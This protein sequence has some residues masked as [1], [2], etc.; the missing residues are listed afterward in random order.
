M[1]IQARNHS[2]F[3]YCVM[4]VVYQL[5]GDGALYINSMFRGKQ[6]QHMFLREWYN[7]MY[8]TWAWELYFANITAPLWA[9][10]ISPDGIWTMAFRADNIQVVDNIYKNITFYIEEWDTTIDLKTSPNAIVTT[11]DG[12]PGEEIRYGRKYNVYAFPNGDIVISYIDGYEIDVRAAFSD[13][14]A[15]V[16]TL[17]T[18]KSL[19]GL[20]PNIQYELLWERDCFTTTNLMVVPQNK[21]IRSYDDIE[22]RNKEGYD[23]S[24]YTWCVGR[25]INTSYFKVMGRYKSGKYNEYDDITS[26]AVFTPPSGTVFDTPNDYTIDVAAY[27]LEG[28]EYTTSFTMETWYEIDSANVVYDNTESG[29]EATTLEGAINECYARL[30]DMNTTLYG[31]RHK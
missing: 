2:P 23:I 24:Y 7:E 29:L 13:T 3:V 14:D 9:R 20:K 5:L 1:S 28:N 22:I 15:S 26:T 6:C 27:D 16:H 21:A 30:R 19:D 8:D 17:V 25:P 4:Q 18:E 10:E 11:Y 31:Y 12:E